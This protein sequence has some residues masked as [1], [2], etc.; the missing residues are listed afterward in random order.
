[1]PRGRLNSWKWVPEISPGV[2]A[3][4]AYGWRPTTLVV[5]NVKKIRGLNL[6]GTPWATSAC[7]R[8]T[9][10]FY[11]LHLLSDFSKIRGKKSEYNAAE[12]LCVS[13]QFG[14]GKPYLL[15]GQVVT[16]NLAAWNRMIFRNEEC[17]VKMLLCTEYT[18]C[19][20]LINAWLENWRKPLPFLICKVE[21]LLTTR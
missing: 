12:N 16:L 5:P 15:L 1:V 10:S 13:W 11:I 6:L 18:I 7:C 19:N 4:G 17:L 14:Q 8:M 3:T 20:L 9:T 21:E 2:K